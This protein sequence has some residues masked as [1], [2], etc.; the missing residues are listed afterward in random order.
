MVFD[1]SEVTQDEHR[2]TVL[3]CSYEVRKTEVHLELNLEN[4]VKGNKVGFYS[5]KRKTRNLL[6]GVARDLM[7]KDKE[8]MELLKIPSSVLPDKTVLQDRHQWESLD[9]VRLNLDGGGSG[10]GD[11]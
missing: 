8:K 7:T 2:D 5:S 11:I 3:V 1:P 9:Q 6:L 4:D 10:W